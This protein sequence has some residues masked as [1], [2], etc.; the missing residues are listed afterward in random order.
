[1]LL[2]LILAFLLSLSIGVYDIPVSD[3]LNYVVG[4]AALD[5]YAENILLNLRLP[6]SAMAMIAGGVLSISGTS[7]QGLFRNPLADPA[8]IG[9]SGGAALGAIFSIVILGGA[10][11]LAADIGYQSDILYHLKRWS[12]TLSAF[13]GALIA[14]WVTYKL[15]TKGSVTNI[16]TLLL[17]GIAIQAITAAGSGILVSLSNDQELRSITF[18][19]LGSVSY[20]GWAD[21]GVG[22]VLG[23]IPALY[24]IRYGS[25]LNILSLGEKDAYYSG[26]DVQSIKKSVIILVALS[27]SCVTSLTGIIAFAGIIGPH[28]TRLVFGYDHQRLLPLSLIMGATV[29]LLADIF[30]RLVIPPAEIPIGILTTAIGGPFFLILLLGLR[31]RGKI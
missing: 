2:L 28:L 26:L 20:V 27:V 15:A 13:I 30:S 11:L 14:I 8:L 29:V 7:L 1:M 12:L 23:L 25:E 18:W 5:S 9:A 3:L 10:G 31:K 24:L 22:V 21:I 16:S 4:Y 17:A 19:S 6:R